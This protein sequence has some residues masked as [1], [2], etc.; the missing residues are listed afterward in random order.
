LQ[1]VFTQLG[2][3]PQ[4]Q[5]FQLQHRAQIAGLGL[6]PFGGLLPQQI[7]GGQLG[8]QAAL[9]ARGLWNTPLVQG[10]AGK[11]QDAYM[12]T[13]NDEKKPTL[14]SFM[15]DSVINSEIVAG[16]LEIGFDGKGFFGTFTQPKRGAAP[17]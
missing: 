4:Q 16:K 7:I 1:P 15:P 12:S 10:I 9:G 14:V 2:S 17:S 8:K 11:L 6:A 13:I 5:A 3:L